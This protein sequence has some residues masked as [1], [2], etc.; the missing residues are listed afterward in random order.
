KHD[1]CL[2]IHLSGVRGGFTSPF[3]GAGVLQREDGRPAQSFNR[4][5][6][7]ALDGVAVLGSFLL[8]EN[9][10]RHKKPRLWAFYIT[11]QN[12][13]SRSVHGEIQRFAH[14]G[15]HLTQRVWACCGVTW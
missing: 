5:N 7:C 10:W 1:A 4:S 9:C 6:P 15:F 2:Y 13:G 3:V 8:T 14:R 12:S 11:R